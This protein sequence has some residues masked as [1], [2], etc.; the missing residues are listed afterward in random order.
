M[1]IDPVTISDAHDPGEG[2]PTPPF[3]ASV[4]SLSRSPWWRQSWVICTPAVPLPPGLHPAAG[5]RQERGP[6]LLAAGPGRWARCLA[7]HR[8]VCL[9]W[10]TDTSPVPGVTCW[11]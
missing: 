1:P 3:G 2:A 11:L 5:S 4:G 10:L 9:T 7:G 8:A 6:G